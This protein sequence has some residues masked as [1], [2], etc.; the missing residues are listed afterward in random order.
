MDFFI[1]T[2]GFGAPIAPPSLFWIFANVLNTSS[3]NLDTHSKG[4]MLFET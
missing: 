2:A 4:T 1:E 3:I